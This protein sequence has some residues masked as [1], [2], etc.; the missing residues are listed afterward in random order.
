MADIIHKGTIPALVYSGS[1]ASAAAS[2]TLVYKTQQ[3]TS[4]L[5]LSLQASLPVYD[6]DD[7]QTITLL[8]S[9]E[10]QRSC[11][12][13]PF[14][15]PLSTDQVNRLKRRD[16]PNLQ[17]LSLDMRTVCQVWH[18]SM[19]VVRP[20]PG[21]ETIFSLI[22]GLARA[23]RV[24]ITF[25]YGHVH[26]DSHAVFD[27]LVK[28]PAQLSSF[29][30]PDMS[31]RLS[32]AETGP[33]LRLCRAMNPPRTRKMRLRPPM[34]R[35]RGK[36]R[37]HCLRHL[38]HRHQSVGYFLPSRPKRGIRH[39]PHQQRSRHHAQGVNVPVSTEHLRYQI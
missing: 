36:G 9:P 26:H 32:R 20:Q 17:V 35:Q 16:I 39:R 3:S 27:Q 7:K 8:Y 34:P 29:P 23:T 12:L 10:S 2:V 24:S 11:R 37:D 28:D 14:S 21:Q 6:F 25:D 4:R 18:P 19:P 13:Q 33:Y 5:L 30:L 1:D 38:P 15:D 22:S 31:R